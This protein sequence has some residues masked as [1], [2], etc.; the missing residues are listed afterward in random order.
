MCCNTMWYK[1]I[2]TSSISF[3]PFYLQIFIFHSPE[4]PF[5]PFSAHSKIYFEKP[6]GSKA[7]YKTKLQELCDVKKWAYPKYSAI[8]VGA[9]HDPRFTASVFINGVFFDSPTP[10]K[11]L[12][13]A[14]HKAAEVALIHFI[15]VSGDGFKTKD[16]SKSIL[17]AE[18]GEGKKV[19]FF[20]F[21]IVL[22]DV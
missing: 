2:H 17:P 3:L 4:C 16:T 19:Q 22:L 5:N 8:K 18:V 14:Q 21:S 13:E 9:D 11:S 1:Y 20:F 15:S 10:C 12:K 7:M 6:D